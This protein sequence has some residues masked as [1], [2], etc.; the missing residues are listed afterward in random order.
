LVSLGTIKE[1]YFERRKIY[2]VGREPKPRE[3]DL[4]IRDLLVKI[5][6]SGYEINSIKLATD[7]ETLLPDLEVN[8]EAAD[9]GEIKTYWEYDSGT[10]GHRELVDKA[11]RYQRHPATAIVFVFE[12]Q[13]RLKNAVEQNPAGHITYAVLDAIQTIKDPVFINA[14]SLTGKPLFTP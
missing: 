10:E 1:M 6:K 3:H 11:R 4:K 13:T 7:L 2:F 8:F 5:I 12:T 14:P 9:A